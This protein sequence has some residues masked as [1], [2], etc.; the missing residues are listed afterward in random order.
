MPVAVDYRTLPFNIARIGDS[1]KYIGRSAYWRLYA[2]ENLMRLLVHSVLSAQISPAWWAVAV[3]PKTDQKVQWVKRDYAKQ[4]SRSSPGAH[5]I[6][7]LFLPD[8]HKIV[9]ANSHLF[10]PLIPDIDQWVLRMEDIRLP[11]NIVGHMNWLNTADE[12]LIDALYSDL[13]ALIRKL[14]RSGMSISIP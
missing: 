3:D 14:S 6:Y 2:I 11:R 7:Y 13:R 4:P 12:Q 8:L 9:L 5:D 10:R 1:G